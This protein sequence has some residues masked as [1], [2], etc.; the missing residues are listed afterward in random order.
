MVEA[1]VQVDPAVMVKALKQVKTLAITLEKTTLEAMAVMRVAQE[2][3]E[4][5]LRVP[6][7]AKVGLS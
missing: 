6:E 1:A 5:P 3:A 4:T 7:A 2:T